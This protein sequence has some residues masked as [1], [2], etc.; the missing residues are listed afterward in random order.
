MKL[1]NKIKIIAIIVGFIFILLISYKF[2]KNYNQSKKN[3]NDF[4]QINQNEIINIE[5]YKIEFDKKILLKTIKNVDDINKVFSF[6]RN[7]IEYQPNHQQIIKSF[8]LKIYLNNNNFY[9]FDLYTANNFNNIIFVDYDNITFK[10][11][12]LYNYFIEYLK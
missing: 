2:I 6:F 4:I 9:I 8:K 11:N 5:F 1:E 7:F 12:E 10:S 3:Y